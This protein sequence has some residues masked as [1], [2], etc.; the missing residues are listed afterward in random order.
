[1]RRYKLGLFF[2]MS[3]YRIDF[4][5]FNL[6]CFFLPIALL[7]FSV[8][9]EI[10][11]CREKQRDDDKEHSKL[12][13]FIDTIQGI[14]GLCIGVSISG[15]VIALLTLAYA[16]VWVIPITNPFFSVWY[17]KQRREDDDD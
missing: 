9:I 16:L 6:P 1:M 11:F 5:D 10:T 7:V 12:V 14:I 8:L 4:S 3:L 2:Y 13:C 17:L 15:T